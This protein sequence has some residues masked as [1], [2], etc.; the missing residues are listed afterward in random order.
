MAKLHELLAVEGSL[1]GTA[2]QILAETITTFSKKP[3]HFTALHRQY[4]PY[5]D[6]KENELPSEDRTLVT[7]V[8]AKLWYTFNT[9]SNWLDAV[10]QKER[11]NQDARA[12]IVIGDMVLATGIPATF[13][14]GLE[15]K[16][17]E[18]RNVIACIPTLQPGIVWEIDPTIGS[19]VYRAKNTSER[20]RTQKIT[21]PVVMY[22]ATDKH[23]AQVEKVSEDVAIGK[24]IETHWSSMLSPADKSSMLGRVDTLL[25][26][27][28]QARQRANNTDVVSI[29][30]GKCLTDYILQS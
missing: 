2:K 17:T 8:P 11:T 22:E 21:K 4:E 25:R 24:Y 23:P 16:L 15:S 1:D 6:G 14:L 7:T 28:K 5:I 3:E 26:A 10:L 29:Q 18:I 20:I 13:L 12:D 30:I 27:V 19:D 9:V